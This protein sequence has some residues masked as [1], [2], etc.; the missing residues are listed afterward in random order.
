MNPPT[1]PRSS[2]YVSVYPTMLIAWPPSRTI[3]PSD[4][5]SVRHSPR[6]ETIGRVMLVQHFVCP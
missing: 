1:L 5:A 6:I 4:G 3:G 2:R